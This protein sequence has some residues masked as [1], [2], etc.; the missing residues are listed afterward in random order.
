MEMSIA[1]TT[2][3]TTTAWLIRGILEAVPCLT[4]MVGSIEY[5]I[6]HDK[7]TEDGDLWVP[8]EEDPTLQR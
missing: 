3:K 4:G 2:G 6:A 1:G 7:L 5:A 8:D